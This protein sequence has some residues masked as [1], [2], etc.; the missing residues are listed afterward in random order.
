LEKII[1]LK[2]LKHIELF[3]I[4][5][6]H[7]KLIESTIPAKIIARGE[8]IK[9]KG[10]ESD[11]MMVDKILY[12]M[13]ETLNGKGALNLMDVKN[14]IN[15]IKPKKN[16][17][18]NQ[19]SASEPVIHYGINGAIKPKT[20]G[21]KLYIELLQNNDI[22]FSI[23]PAG[24]GK[25]FLAVAF[26]VSALENHEVDRIILCRPAVEAGENLG[27]LPGDLKDKVDPYLAPLYDSLNI[28]YDKN[29]LGNLLESKI[30]EIAPL[31]YMRGR[32]LDRAYII[33]DEAQNTT[34][35]QMKMFLTRLGIGS[36][37][38]VTGDITQVDLKKRSDSGLI[39]VAKILKDVEGVSFVKLNQSDVVRH[40]LVMKIIEAYDKIKI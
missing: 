3:G 4:A 7:I 10:E 5:D 25:T 38:I 8:M 35:M 6:E 17:V 19:E 29:K 30:I 34:A 31:A 22:V 39:Q 15:I 33:L 26:A 32:T 13:M 12:E 11:V 1:E 18:F 24:T 9:I 21:Q 36:R 20:R 40:H 2:S 27:F 16:T 37:A 28:L 14:L 23:G